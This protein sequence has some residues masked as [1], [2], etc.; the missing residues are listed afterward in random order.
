VAFDAVRFS[1]A[2]ILFTAALLKTHQSATEPGFG[3]GF[4]ESRWLVIGVV[5]FELL[6]GFWLASGFWRRWACWVALATFSL[7]AVVAATKAVAG[8]PSCGCFGRVPTSPWFA[9]SIDLLAVLALW[10][11]RPRCVACG[12]RSSGPTD[13]GATDFRPDSPA[14]RWTTRTCFAGVWLAVALAVGLGGVSVPDSNVLAA[15]GSRFGNVIVIE[16]ERMLGKPFELARFID[17]GHR[18]MGGDW[19]VLLYRADC[20]ECHSVVSSWASAGDDNRGRG[21]RALIEVPPPATQDSVPACNALRGQLV[22]GREWF[23]R[24]PLLVRVRDGTVVATYR[25]AEDAI[26]ASATAAGS[27]D[28]I[29]QGGDCGAR[30]L[31]VVCALSGRRHS[32]GSCRE[33][34]EG[35][36]NGVSMLALK[37]ACEGLG[38]DVSACRGSFEVVRNHLQRWNGWAIMHVLPSH[39]VVA[40]RALPGDHICVVDPSGGVREVDESGFLDFF[41]WQGNMLLISEPPWPGGIR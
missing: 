12:E 2:V 32:L 27:D 13:V 23:V 8:E 5:Q 26:R 21:K 3:G 34:L 15:I 37:K 29:A 31:Y 38:F 9:L 39:F 35:N 14:Q 6:L 16:P 24:T 4:F 10:Y 11:S 18:L 20:S 40:A 25:T 30:C 19:M 36:A 1:L 41:Q 28:Q 7:F 22:E 33:S 17:V